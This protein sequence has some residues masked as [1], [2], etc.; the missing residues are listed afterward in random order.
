MNRLLFPVVIEKD[1][2][3][4]FASCP[5]LQGCYTQGDSCE[6]TLRKIQEMAFMALL[7][8]AMKFPVG[9]AGISCADGR[10]YTRIFSNC[11]PTLDGIAMAM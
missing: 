7:V 10:F 8:G 6:E 5:T 2:E 11:T 4:Y 9:M 3:G 1:E